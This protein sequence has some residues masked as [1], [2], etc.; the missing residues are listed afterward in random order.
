MMKEDRE[1]SKIEGGCTDG[2]VFDPGVRR[3][4]G[5]FNGVTCRVELEG[6]NRCSVRAR[7][8]SR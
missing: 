7:V 2:R 3:M 4:P 8:Q 6:E 5:T 1:Q